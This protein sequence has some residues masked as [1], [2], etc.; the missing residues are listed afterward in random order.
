[1][2]MSVQHQHSQGTHFRFLDLAYERWVIVAVGDEGGKRASSP[3]KS[4]RS[5]MRRQRLARM[6]RREAL[7][8]GGKG[9]VIQR[10]LALLP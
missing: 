6:A 10:A 3:T 7:E 5:G 4:M 8:V 1:M 9:L 2:W